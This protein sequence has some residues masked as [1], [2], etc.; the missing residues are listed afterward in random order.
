MKNI[1]LYNILQKA[2]LFLRM[3]SKRYS[4]EYTYKKSPAFPQGF[5]MYV[6]LLIKPTI[7]VLEPSP[8]G[9]VVLIIVF[10]SLDFLQSIFR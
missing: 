1:I 10:R 6:R 9:I 2:A 4:I 5:S 7:D 8:I 3:R